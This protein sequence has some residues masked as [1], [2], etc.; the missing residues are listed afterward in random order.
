MNERPCPD[1]LLVASRRRGLSDLERKALS[2]HLA[3]CELCRV[4]AVA[5]TLLREPPFAGGAAG[6]AAA[7]VEPRIARSWSA[8]RNG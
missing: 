3:R 5:A 2:A 1:D 6:D 8:W 4:G 7:A